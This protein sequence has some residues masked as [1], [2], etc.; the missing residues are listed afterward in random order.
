[1]KSYSNYSLENQFSGWTRIDMLLALY[2]RAISETMAAKEAKL[3]GDENRLAQ[4][5]IVANRLMLALHGGLKIDEYPLAMD[6]A[7][8]LNFVVF[9]LEQHNFDEAIHFL[10][11]TKSAYESIRDEAASLEK[12]GTIPA[13]NKRPGLDA[14]A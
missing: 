5:L 10:E 7:R 11:K 14:I 13:L 3:A 12:N 2:E 4:K 6:I 9:R 1:M 8:L